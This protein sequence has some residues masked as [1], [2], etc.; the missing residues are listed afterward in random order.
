MN[1]PSFSFSFFFQAE[2]GIR[3]GTVTGVQTCALPISFSDTVDRR[4]NEW[5][6]GQEVLGRKFT[7]EQVEWLAMIKE[8]I[9]TSASI[10]IEDF[11]YV[12]FYEK[13][14]RVRATRIFGQEL[15]TILKELNEALVA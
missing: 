4:F 10:D 13:G 8:H 7:P 5:F 14:G 9:A 12:P 3:D 15:N 1:V 2:D 6:N 11:D